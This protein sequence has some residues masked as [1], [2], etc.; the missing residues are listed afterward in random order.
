MM[1]KL[2]DFL[3]ASLGADPAGFVVLEDELAT[4]EAYL[5]IESVR[6]G[7]RLN[8]EVVCPDGLADA[9][10]PSF[11]LQPLVENAVKYAVAPSSRTVTIRV[12]AADDGEDLVLTVEDDGEAEGRGP[13]RSGTGVGLANV[14]ERLR[15]LYGDRGVLEAAPRSRGFL[16][17]A[18]LPLARASA[19]RLEAT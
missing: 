1:Q 11:L 10:V 9:L 13:T 16:A 18:R 17:L 19:A 15:A 8:V 2:S 4:V 5:D 7:E 3:R 14:R 6:F 12:E